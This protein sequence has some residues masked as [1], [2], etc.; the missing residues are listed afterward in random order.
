MRCFRNQR[1]ALSRFL[2]RGWV[3]SGVLLF[4]FAWIAPAVAAGSDKPRCTEE[5]TVTAKV[6]ALEQIYYYNRFGSSNPSGMMYAVR[7]DV[8]KEGSGEPIPL[9]ADKTVDSELA[10]DV[11]LRDGKRPRP[12]VLRA[13]EGDCLRV[14]FTNLLSH[15]TSGQDIVR[16][17]SSGAPI[18]IDAEEPATRHASMHV[19]GLN[20]V[21][22]IQ[23][24]GSNVG[25]NQSSLAA[26][27][28]T[29]TDMWYAKQQGGYLF[30]SMAG[31]AGGE[32][33][34]GQLGLGLFG[35]VN[36]Q[37]SGSKW[38]RSQPSPHFLAERVG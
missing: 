31:P 38:Y 19:N 11:R 26:P 34:G 16:E 21:D 9:N 35:S 22:G 5:N 28:E 2:P 36:V 17:P 37:P 29:V 8:V 7:R 14:T 6:V 24:D 4:G 33:D 27:G 12:L 15:T 25:R 30:Y 23:S 10:G 3:G 20:L 13:N 18:L 32:G 1:L